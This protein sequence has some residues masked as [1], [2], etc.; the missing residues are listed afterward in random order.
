MTRQ[1]NKDFTGYHQFRNARGSFEVFHSRKGFELDGWYWWACSAGCLPDSDAV[2][3][4]MT[5][6]Q[7]FQDANGITRRQRRAR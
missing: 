2:G 7:A 4:F 3:P 6:K 1:S 5:A